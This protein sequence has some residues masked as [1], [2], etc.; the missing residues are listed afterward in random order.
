MKMTKLVLPL[1][2][3]AGSLLGQEASI[4]GVVTDP[5]QAMVP[6]VSVTITN[7]ATGVAH[8][9]QTNDEGFYVVPF[10]TPGA[11][12]AEASKSGF[13]AVVKSGINL[14][15][16]Q[17]AR[18]DFT[19]E[20]GAVSQTVEVSAAA[21]LIDSQSSVVGQVIGNK[22]IVELPLNGR[23]YLELAQLT[24]G[25]AP[26]RDS[27]SGGAGAFASVGQH[28]AQTNI[29]L[30]GVDNSSRLSGGMLGNQA[31]IVTPSIDAVQ[32]F[33]VVTN[34]NSA[35]YG[36]R[37]GGTVLVTTKPGTNDLH[38]SL[39]EFL[40][41]DK[42]DGANFFAVGRPKPSYRHNQFGGT[43]GGPI[44]RNRTFVF[45]SYE[46]L[47]VRQG[48]SRLTTVPGDAV[49]RGEFPATRTIY[50]WTTTSE[51][52]PG[53]F[54]RQPFANNQIPASR[55]DP[56]TRKVIDLYPMPNLPGLVNNH[57][58]SPSQQNRSDQVDMRLDHLFTQNHRSFVR[59][60]RRE[61]DIVTPGNL[62]LPADSGW[63]TTSM[64]AHN[65]AGN[66]N[67]VLSPS[68]NNEFRVG[69][70]TSDGAFDLPW[71][72]RLD[73]G[74]PGIPDF[75]D[76][77]ARG[78]PRFQPTGYA[79]IGS[80]SFWPNNNDLNVFQITD[81]LLVIRGRH[82]LKF[83]FDFRR[84]NLFRRAARFARG[85]FNFNGAFSQDPQNR[86]RTGDAMAD[87]L[88][89]VSTTSTLGNPNGETA[90]TH[91]YAGFIQND[92][93][94][95]PRLTL[96]LGVR[97]EMFG[98]PSFKNL[99]ETPVSIFKFAYGS[100]DYQILRPKDES[101]CGCERDLNN[102]APRIGLAYQVTPRMVVR[103]GFGVMYGQPDSIS[104]FGD[105]RFQNLPPEFTEIT[106]P[107]DSL[108]QPSRIVSQGFPAGLFPATS[109][110]EDVFVNTAD[111]FIPT[112]Y[113]MQ[114]FTDIQHELPKDAVLT[115]SYIGSG[116]RQLTQL[117]N[118]NQPLTPGPGSVKSRSPWPYFGWIMY[119]QAIGNASYQ[120]LT[121]K[122][123]KR[124]SQGLSLL[125]AYTWAHSI[126][127]A[128]E[129][130]NTAGGQELQDS[131][132]L[133]RHRANSS[134]DIRHSFVASPVYDL[135]FGKGRTWLNTS[136][137]VDWILGGWQ[138]SGILQLRSGPP[139]TPLVSVD[140]S[141]TGTTNPTG[142]TSNQ[143]HPDRIRNGELPASERSIDRWFDVSAFAIPANYTYGNSGR[144]ILRGP[145]F[146]N[147]DFKIGKNFNIREGK[148][149]EFRCELFNATNTPHF[150]LPAP[151]VNLATAGRIT[152]AGAPRHIQ[153]GLKFVY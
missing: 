78:L 115:L 116:T 87:F 112:Q 76:A 48:L 144:N 26:A 107:T 17:A 44:L 136:G 122:V 83:G 64:L 53:R 30:D 15:V 113:S 141:N 103:S 142:G 32:E 86:G 16:G 123:E 104:F 19:L 3:L 24:A 139:F 81:Q 140:I 127:N 57:F 73:L 68:I 56:I 114:W 63:Q 69:V 45:G 128:V 34:N 60:S 94:V 37:M 20:V 82:V 46:G 88:L 100:Q 31:Q 111:R 27:R 52:G 14:D 55:V 125:A 4:R 8:T 6:G 25:V 89:G 22:S 120:A 102:F 18:L 85:F 138:I 129:A 148:R 54:V 47:R 98:P 95:T 65:V 119:R 7:V 105:A 151:N 61:F 33:K 90:V 118:L 101:D 74:I 40:R 58:F 108:R 133:K 121:A 29:S 9:V 80:P 50:D 75:G 124:Y 137:P 84:E 147:L 1:L 72:D 153:F 49:R 39:Y 36:F 109:V 134:F 146:R 2:C 91:N 67:S 143:N 21:T 71:K 117:R 41:N 135:P 132:D 126:D 152:A 43:I 96:N 70:I 59:W 99:E 79:Q 150:A 12:R 106:F 66:L 13:A 62:P 97:W 28:G 93:R 35:E 92:W 131:Y 38:G 10:L 145:N 149:L 23:N 51:A 77:N 11:Y 42:L 5:A 130:L 110:L